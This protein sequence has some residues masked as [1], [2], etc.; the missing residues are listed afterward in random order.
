MNSIPD[1]NQKSQPVKAGQGIPLTAIMRDQQDP[2]GNEPKSRSS[3]GNTAGSIFGKFF[4]K[5]D[6]DDQSAGKADRA[7]SQ[8]DL[9]SI[10]IA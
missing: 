8:A 7:Q 9:F 4:K 10:D 6:R 1:N 2:S 5:K 3:F